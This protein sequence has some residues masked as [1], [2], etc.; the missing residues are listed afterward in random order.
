MSDIVREGTHSARVALTGSQVRSE[1]IL[2]NGGSRVLLSEGDDRWY[3][4][5]FFIARMVYGFPGANGGH[6]IIWQF[7]QIGTGNVGS[8]RLS[9]S[10][11]DYGPGGFDGQQRGKGL[12]LE[13]DG[14]GGQGDRFLEPL[15]EQAWHDVAVH[16]GVSTQKAG[17]YRVYLDGQ[18]GRLG[19]QCQHAHAR[20]QP[21]PVPERPV[22]RRRRQLRDQAG[23]GAP[24]HLDGRRLASLARQAPAT[25]W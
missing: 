24:R 20:L 22:P 7:H 9:L 14:P 8:P 10:L 23:R 1:L 18:L 11:S 2:A 17:F 13:A 6:N 19:R 25:R 4:F 21:G 16:L 5:S 12:W 3:G 15:A